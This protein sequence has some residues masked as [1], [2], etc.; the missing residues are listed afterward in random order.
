MKI[1]EIFFVLGLAFILSIFDIRFCPF[2]YLFNIPCPGCGLTRAFKLLLKGKFLQSLNFNIL[3]LPILILI[4][5]FI[6][7]PNHIKK[8]NKKIIYFLGFILMIISFIINIFNPL[9]Y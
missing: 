9:L 4:L 5:T 2:F 6:F 8:I 3:P 7:F 1:K